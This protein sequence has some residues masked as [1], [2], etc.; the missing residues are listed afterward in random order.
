MYLFWFVTPFSI[1]EA[2]ASPA[3]TLVKRLCESAYPL[4][5]IIAPVWVRMVFF[6]ASACACVEQ[7]CKPK[8]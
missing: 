4:A 8:I 1:F 5:L 7:D 6:R 3:S 2:M